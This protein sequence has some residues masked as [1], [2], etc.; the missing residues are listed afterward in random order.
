MDCAYCP[1]SYRN[2]KIL[3]N[4]NFDKQMR[5]MVNVLTSRVFNGG[6]FNKLIIYGGEP[7]LYFEQVRRIVD[8]YKKHRNNSDV[9]FCTNGIKVNSEIISYCRDNNISL[10]VNLDGKPGLI[11]SIKTLSKEEWSHITNTL[12][13]FRK[14]NVYFDFS[15]T[16]TPAFIED[17]KN[18]INFLESLLPRSIG[19]NFLRDRKAQRIFNIQDGKTYLADAMSL[20][21]KYNSI[22]NYNRNKKMKSFKEKAQIPDCIC[23]GLGITITPDGNYTTCGIFSGQKYTTPE[24]LLEQMHENHNRLFLREPENSV[25]NLATFGGGCAK[26]LVNDNRN[27]A[28][29]NAIISFNEFVHEKI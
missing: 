18:Q 10:T 4:K 5:S 29:Q 2:N 3:A 27:F 21:F 28:E 1:F 20:V 9:T 19:F 17:F 11:R 7:L 25:K 24:A 22:L 26:L 6:S 16:I 8:E 12:L 13:L 15:T 14:N 23:T